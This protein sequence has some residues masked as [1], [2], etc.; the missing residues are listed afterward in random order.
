MQGIRIVEL[1]RCKMV[2]SGYADDGDPFAEDGLNVFVPI[3][4]KQR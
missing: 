2:S 4:P 3:R 1:P